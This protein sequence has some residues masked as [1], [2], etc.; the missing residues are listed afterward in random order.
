MGLF[1]VE[2][3]DRKGAL[4]LRLETRAAHLAWLEGLGA[5]VKLGGPLLEAAGATPVGSL[6]IFEA[7]D[8]AS[9]DALLAEDPYVK[10]GLF[11]TVTVQPFRWV[12]RPPAELA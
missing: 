3:R 7:A 1:V 5:V 12:I 11:E 9:L 2:A 10:A 6:L 8:R 4:A